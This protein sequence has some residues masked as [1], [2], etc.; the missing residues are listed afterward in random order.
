MFVYLWIFIKMIFLQF[1][2]VTLAIKCIVTSG[3]FNLYKVL[4]F[5]MSFI[6]RKRKPWILKFC[7]WPYIDDYEGMVSLK[8]WIYVLFILSMIVVF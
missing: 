5:W 4:N 2:Y 3:E 1:Q 7:G 8:I 6:V